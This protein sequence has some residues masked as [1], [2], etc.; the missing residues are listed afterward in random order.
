M[1][2]IS[3]F[4]YSINYFICLLT[5]RRTNQ[6]GGYNYVS[7]SLGFTITTLSQAPPSHKVSHKSLA[8][9]HYL[10]IVTNTV[11]DNAI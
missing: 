1:F 4:V 10:Y 5:T 6:I 2:P 8:T 7:A 3:Y 9:M 11:C